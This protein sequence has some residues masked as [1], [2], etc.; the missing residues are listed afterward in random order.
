MT[1]KL[2]PAFVLT[3]FFFGLGTAQ[4]VSGESFLIFHDGAGL[5][6]TDLRGLNSERLTSDPRDSAARISPN[7]KSF[8]FWRGTSL[9]TMATDRSDFRILVPE[10]AVVKGRHLCWNSDGSKIAFAEGTPG[11]TK[12]HI[13]N[14][15]GTGHRIISTLDDFGQPPWCDW[16]ADD[17]EIYIS[18]G[19]PANA[20]ALEVTICR[21]NGSGCEQITRSP[22]SS[23]SELPV[24]SGDR[25]FLFYI[26][27]PG[28]FAG[29]RTLVRADL[30]A[31]NVEPL[32]DGTTNVVP[33]RS[34]GGRL[35]F[36][37]RPPGGTPHLFS[38][39]EDGTDRRQESVRAEGIPQSVDVFIDGE[40]RG[41]FFD[42]FTGDLTNQW[43]LSGGHQSA[44]GL[45][46]C[47]FE[48]GP[49]NNLFCRDLVEDQSALGQVR[50]EG[51]VA[52]GVRLG[53]E[54]ASIE[55]FPTS[56][57]FAAKVRLL[58]SVEDF[59]SHASVKAFFTWG[60]GN[61]P[62][63]HME[64]DFEVITGNSRVY[65]QQGWAS[66]EELDA[67]QSPRL[68]TVTHADGGAR[69]IPTGLISLGEF[70]TEQFT[71]VVGITCQADC[72]TEAPILR[73][74]YSVVTLGG[75]GVTLG[76]TE[77]R[78]SSMI[79]ELRAMFNV[80]WLDPV[81]QCR[82]PRDRRGPPTSSALPDD[83][84]TQALEVEWFLHSPELLDPIEAH[85]LGEELD[86]EN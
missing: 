53:S 41:L 26:Q 25:N 21:T 70:G 13:V 42:G 16:T 38:F 19:Q 71:F 86:S 76:S 40:P 60:T 79:S 10:V 34:L 29:V 6:R 23:L 50:L 83:A 54:I 24:L 17:R 75:L 57:T 69:D 20:A 18:F 85:E 32:T 66:R 58:G 28:P 14:A 80:W 5:V 33:V 49:Q 15:D 59:R 81:D 45:T 74:D 37:E 78:H 7:G 35:Y 56:G 68:Q 82:E 9:A 44:P 39:L 52:E 73:A 48:R 3:L 51:L 55:R 46:E 84:A 65:S 27:R 12:L 61:S 11:N 67:L 8:V 2:T 72:E 77:T 43:L 31:R 22:G 30:D 63:F 1:G 4:S 62:Q 64:H 36:V 47:S